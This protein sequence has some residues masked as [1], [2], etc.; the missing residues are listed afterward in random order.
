MSKK[1]R[2]LFSLFQ[3]PCA[4]CIQLICWIFH[5][6]PR[7]NEE[8][9]CKMF[10]NW[11]WFILYHGEDYYSCNS[12]EYFPKVS[13]GARR[14][15]TLQSI[16][17]WLGKRISSEIW[18]N[19]SSLQIMAKTKSTPKLFILSKNGIKSNTAKLNWSWGWAW[20]NE[21]NNKMKTYRQPIKDT[22]S[23]A[24]LW[25]SLFLSIVNS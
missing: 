4:M 12:K 15:I 8:I 10:Q 14:A 11:D 24:Q 6:S 7:C 19:V 17:P 23:L 18:N 20:Q 5:N 9:T 2:A 22:L 16:S 3:I 25:P 1:N 21:D 13:T